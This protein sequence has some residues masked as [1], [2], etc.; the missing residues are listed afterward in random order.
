MNYSR[1]R[2]A[3]ATLSLVL[4]LSDSSLCPPIDRDWGSG[5]GGLHKEGALARLCEILA[6]ETVHDGDEFMVELLKEVKLENF[7]MNLKRVS[8]QIA[9]VIHLH[10]EGDLTLGVADVVGSDLV[11]VLQVDLHP[12]L[13]VN[14]IVRLLV[15]IL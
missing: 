6:L 12:E 4:D 1:E 11:P 5:V 3:R 10:G 15:K 14:L 9:K 2:P 13:F 8:Y 7:Q